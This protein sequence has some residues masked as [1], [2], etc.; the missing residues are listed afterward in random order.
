MSAAYKRGTASA[1]AHSGPCRLVAVHATLDTGA[2]TVAVYDGSDANGTLVLTLAVNGSSAGF[3]P[4]VPIA[5]STGLYV[6]VTNGC[7]YTLV[8]I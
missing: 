8:W 6:T 5:L 7:E 2:G 3:A 1:L 4:A